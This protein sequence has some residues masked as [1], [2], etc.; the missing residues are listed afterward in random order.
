MDIFLLFVKNIFFDA[1]DLLSE[2]FKLIDY[3]YYIRCLNN[4]AVDT[5]CD[6]SL[7]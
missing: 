5:Y 1:W 7:I 3:K 4:K 2:W 6:D